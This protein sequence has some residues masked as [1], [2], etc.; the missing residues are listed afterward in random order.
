MRTLEDMA[1]RGGLGALRT[2]ANDVRLSSAAQPP[3]RGVSAPAQVRD[4]ANTAGAKPRFAPPA[5]RHAHLTVVRAI[6][7]TPP[8][9]AN[10]AAG[11]ASGQGKHRMRRQTRPQGMALWLIGMT[12]ALLVCLLTQ[13]LIALYVPSRWTL[14]KDL[15]EVY[16]GWIGVWL[17][18]VAASLA[19]HGRAQSRSRPRARKSNRRP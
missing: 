1:S 2:S 6:P 9:P 14:I 18:A 7:V 5:G 11:H 12:L 10:M 16:A 17:T 13:T 3:V 19:I 8:R 15:S 4:Y